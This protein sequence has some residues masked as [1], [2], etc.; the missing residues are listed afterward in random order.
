MGK[1]TSGAQDRA[2]KSRLERPHPNPKKKLVPKFS[3]TPKPRTKRKA[4][5]L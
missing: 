4:M 5:Y 2:T 3:D 1:A